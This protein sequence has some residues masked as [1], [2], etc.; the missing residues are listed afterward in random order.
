MNS[1]EVSIQFAQM[2][3]KPVCKGLMQKEVIRSQKKLRLVKFQ[4]G[5][6][7]QD[8]CLKGHIGYVV[9]GSCSIHF[10]GAE[11]GFSAGDAL[12]IE[13]GNTH[14]HKMVMAKNESVTL[15]LVEDL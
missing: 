13:P 14:R 4:E 9:E 10:N 2:E 6:V 5:F 12:F 3:W 15:F 7:E 1:V 8:W 11:K